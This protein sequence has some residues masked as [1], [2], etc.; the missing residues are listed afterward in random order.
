M[1]RVFIGFVMLRANARV[2]AWKRRVGATLFGIAVTTRVLAGGSGLNVAVVVNQNSTNSV[3]LGNYY[4][5]QRAVPPQNLIR[6]NWTGDNIAWTTADF[7][8][9]LRTPFTAALASRQLTNQIEVVLL[10]MDI[11]YRVTL[12]TGSSAT[13]GSNSTTAALFYG[14]KPD[15][16]S[17]SCPAG[18]PSCNLAPGSTNLYAGSE[19]IFRSTPPLSAT[20][21]SWLVMMITASNLAQAKQIL[22]NGVNGDG[23]FPTQKVFLAKTTDLDRN[24]RYFAFDNAVFD[25][26]L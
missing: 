17:G 19:G 12:T 16:C 3:E 8:A 1:N 5:E 20:S 23:A 9:F 14:F 11:P 26:Q 24:V 21:N 18:L 22:N 6:I 13:S 2:T 25:T 15:G 10:S 7:D 4:C